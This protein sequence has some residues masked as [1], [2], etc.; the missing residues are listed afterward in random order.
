MKPKRLKRSNNRR[1]DG[2]TI[3]VL[4]GLALTAA[5]SGQVAAPVPRFRTWAETPPMGWNSWD[6]FGTTVTEAQTDERPTTWPRSCAARLEYIVV[7]IQWYEPEAPATT[8]AP[9]RS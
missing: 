6:C 5:L 1:M 3:R 4:V 2:L 7:D 8:I 9:A